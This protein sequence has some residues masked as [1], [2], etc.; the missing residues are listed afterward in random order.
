MGDADVPIVEIRARTT[1]DACEGPAGAAAG[2]L[3]LGGLLRLAA[4]RA[5]SGAAVA[6][7]RTG[8]GGVARRSVL[9]GLLAFPPVVGRVEPRAL[10]VH[11]DRMQ[12]AL[13]RSL[14][15]D[16]TRG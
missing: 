16:R 14:A 6:A 10:V 7:R 12:D 9:R 4:G 8:R 2:D 5:R 13:Q 15:A 11:G 1:Q 3:G